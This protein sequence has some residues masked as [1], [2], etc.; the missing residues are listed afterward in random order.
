MNQKIIKVVWICHFLNAEMQSLLPLWRVKNEFASWIPNLLKGFEHREGIELHVIVPLEYLKRT[1]ILTLRRIHYYFIPYG[2]PIWHRHWPRFCRFDLYTN[3]FF[4]RKKVRKIINTIQPDLINLIGAEN[5]NYSPAILDYRND[6]PVLIT[7]QGFI[8]QVE[9]ELKSTMHLRKRIK[10]EDQILKSFKYFCGELDSSIYISRYNSNHVFFRFYFPV[11]ENL[12]EATKDN[13]KKFDCIYFGKLSRSKG[14]EDFIKVIAILKNEIPDIT[15][16]IVG[17]GDATPYK[18]IAK[19]LNCYNNIKFLGFVETQ[20]QLFGYVKSSRVFLAPT[21]IDRLPSTI[22]EA[23][24]LKIPIVAYST[25]GIPFINEHDENILIIETGNYKE[26]ARQTLL[27]LRNKVFREQL[28]QKA[29]YYA[30]DEY[31]LKKNTFRLV[32]AY[33]EIVNT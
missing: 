18:A 25:G 5:L 11:N 19:E 33:K 8:K 31:S 26:M 13:G 1:T 4:F 30:S 7:I 2:I 29:F 9:D 24:F 6:F 23:M 15:A 17:G 10:T 14:A 28:V 22:R 12:V 20:K 27:L 3:L 16:C 21:Y 32:S